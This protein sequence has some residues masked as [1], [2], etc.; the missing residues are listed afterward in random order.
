MMRH[1]LTM[2]ELILSLFTVQQAHTGN[3]CIDLYP[4]MADEIL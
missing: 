3:P 4:S 2:T 1:F